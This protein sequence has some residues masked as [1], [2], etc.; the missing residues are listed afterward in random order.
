ML[1]IAK[2]AIEHPTFWDEKNMALAEAQLAAAEQ[3]WQEAFFHYEAAIEILARKGLRLEWAR[4]L[5]EWAGANIARGKTEDF[6]RAKELY[7][8]AQNLFEEIDT[9]YYSNYV[10]EQIDRLERSSV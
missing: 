7:L 5:Q 1:D 2:Q 4:T 10:E 8:E 9:T 6:E 3:R